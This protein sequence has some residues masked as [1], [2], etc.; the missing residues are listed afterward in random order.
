[1]YMSLVSLLRLNTLFPHRVHQLWRRLS[2]QALVCTQPVC[3][4]SRARPNSWCSFFPTTS[5]LLS[6]PSSPPAPSLH[7]DPPPGVTRTDSQHLAWTG[8]LAGCPP[9]GGWMKT[10]FKSPAAPRPRADGGELR[11]IHQTLKILP[12]SVWGSLEAEEF[13][14][15]QTEAEENPKW[16]CSYSN[17]I[18]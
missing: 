17:N 6:L 16:M 5:S 18:L 8:G 4:L 2:L 9:T 13:F 14:F 15:F 1:M 7:P 12:M 3:S 10:P 11:K